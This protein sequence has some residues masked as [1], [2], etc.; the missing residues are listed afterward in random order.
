MSLYVLLEFICDYC[1]V[2][3][4]RDFTS[5]QGEPEWD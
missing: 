2:G 4:M 1:E 3:I 5:F